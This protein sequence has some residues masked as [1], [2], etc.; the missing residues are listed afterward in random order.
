LD[1]EAI[2]QH[3]KEVKEEEEVKKGQA[4]IVEW[5]D[6]KD[7]PPKQLKHKVF[8]T[9]HKSKMFREILDLSFQ[10]Q[11]EIGCFIHSINETIDQMGHSLAFLI[12]EIA[13][14]GPKDFGS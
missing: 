10:L 13:E 1:P 5:D 9:I 8:L 2:K 11:L 4:Q 12:H 7:D 6:I 14:A 3:L